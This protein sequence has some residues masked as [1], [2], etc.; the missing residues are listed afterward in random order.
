MVRNFWQEFKE[1]AFKGNMLDL[2]V[3]VVIGTAFGAV[4]NSLV[5]N[6]I[7]PAVSYVQPSSVGY[8]AWHLGRIQ[9]GAFISEL[10]TFL[11]ISATVFLLIVKIVGTL[12]KRATA[13]PP[14]PEPVTK[15]CPFCLMTIPIKALK[16]G[17]CTADLSPAAGAV[18]G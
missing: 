13:P 5:K 2:A 1:F 10:V 12:L 7:M 8:Q 9:I 15:E 6:I 4:V 17:H 18:S 16:C 3:A 11:I 14:P